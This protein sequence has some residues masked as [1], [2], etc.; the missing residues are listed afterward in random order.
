MK[1]A[2]CCIG[3]VK[4]RGKPYFP[5][6][7]RVFRGDLS[8]RN[9]EQAA[10]MFS[11]RLRSLAAVFTLRRRECCRCR[12]G[13]SGSCSRRSLSPV[14]TV[15]VGVYLFDLR[16]DLFA[17]D[18]LVF[19]FSLIVESDLCHLLAELRPIASL[20]FHSLY[21]FDSSF[22]VSGSGIKYPASGPPA[23]VGRGFGRP[24]Y[25]T[26]LC[27]DIT[28]TGR[29]V[30]LI[31]GRRCRIRWLGRTNRLIRHFS[32]GRCGGRLANRNVAV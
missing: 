13:C 28:K 20:L 10:R 29:F 24:D 3:C 32:L 9:T 11:R 12:P 5:D 31:G 18:L 7:R 4:C 22:V 26:H 16:C 15:A 1:E 17:C 21:F 30:I 6:G 27:G 19:R 25:L 14:E 8:G 2:F 23:G